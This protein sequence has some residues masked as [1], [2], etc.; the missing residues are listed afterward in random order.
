MR[1]LFSFV[2]F[3]VLGLCL[4]VPVQV[5]AKEVSI[6]D[7]LGYLSSEE[8]TKL[9]A[10]ASQ[11]SEKYDINVLVMINDID[12][13]SDNFARDVIEANGPDTY[14]EGYIGMIVNMSDRSYW[15]DAYGDDPRAVFTQ[16]RTDRLSDII[17]D[18]LRDGDYYG[19]I[20][21][22][23]TDVSKQLA[24]H[25]SPMG[26]LKAPFLYPMQSFLG[27]AISGVIALASAGIWTAVKSSRHKD[28]G[29]R[30]NA[31]GYDG[32]LNLRG[33]QDSFSHF[34]QTRMPRPKQ[35]NSGG[36]G[37]QGGGGGGGHTGSGGHF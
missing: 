30:L 34:Y 5:Q 26:F 22:F 23:L 20:D 12:A 31:A 24:L 37:F 9:E 21:G 29:V 25:S 35:T 16:S 7:D 13:Y 10:K 4:L 27:I 19:A 15:V 2:L 36:G 28:K 33:K 3:F 6:S 1:K 32:G 17:L 11:I 18:H 8:L 14:P